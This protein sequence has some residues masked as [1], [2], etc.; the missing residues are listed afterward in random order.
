MRPSELPGPTARSRTR[1]ERRFPRRHF[2]NTRPS[3]C[4]R[5]R[6]GE[7]Q[8]EAG[9]GRLPEDSQPRQPGRQRVRGQAGGLVLLP[10]P[11]LQSHPFLCSPG[12]LSFL[13]YFLFFKERLLILFPPLPPCILSRGWRTT[14]GDW[15]SLLWSRRTT[16]WSIRCSFLMRVLSS[17][18]FLKSSSGGTSAEVHPSS[19]NDFS[20]PGSP[21]PLYH[22]P[23]PPPLSHPPCPL[24]HM[25]RGLNWIYLS[26]V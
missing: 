21:H 16:P 11:P 2:L 6:R 4:S 19:D 3:R 20:P 8:S 23:A 1:G 17:F 9:G 15:T 14:R 24:P 25:W 13:V 22:G 7:G 26:N 5:Q 18:C 12:F 10:L